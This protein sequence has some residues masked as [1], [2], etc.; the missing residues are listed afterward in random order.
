MTFNE[1]LMKATGTTLV[2]VERLAALEAVAEAARQLAT[3]RANEELYLYGDIYTDEQQAAYDAFV[4]AL[5]AVDA[6][7][8]ALKET[9]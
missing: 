1:G 6:A 5:D 7:L 3:A 2:T 4:K 9:K 8:T